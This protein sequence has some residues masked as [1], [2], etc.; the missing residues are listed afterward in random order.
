MK[1]TIS[2]ILLSSLLTTPLAGLAT[3]T[4]TTAPQASSYVITEKDKDGKVIKTYEIHTYTNN[5]ATQLDPKQTRALVEQ[6]Q[7]QQKQIQEDF[8]KLMTDS[9]RIF[10]EEP[11]F[12]PMMPIIVLQP[13]PVM[14]QNVQNKTSADKKETTSSIKK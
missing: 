13:G 6:M 11:F 9:M 5:N 14:P 3:T 4:Q 8:N 10:K 1:K 12:A 2:I 7:K